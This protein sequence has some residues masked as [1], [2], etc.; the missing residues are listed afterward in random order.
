MKEK[1]TVATYEIGRIKSRMKD[2]MAGMKD[3]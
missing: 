1:L 3:E 2:K